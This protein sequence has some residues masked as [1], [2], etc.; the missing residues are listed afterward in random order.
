M[1]K[2]TKP[3]KNIV[4]KLK[5]RRNNLEKAGVVYKIECKE[6]ESNYIGEAGRCVQDRIDEH[7]KDARKIMKDLIFINM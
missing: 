1:F 6:C 2:S 5:D 4:C 7:K 3:V